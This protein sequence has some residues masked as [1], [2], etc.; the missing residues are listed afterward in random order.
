MAGSGKWSSTT[1][2]RSNDLTAGTLW[3]ERLIAS[4]TRLSPECSTG[5]GVDPALPSLAGDLGEASVTLNEAK[6]SRARVP[7]E[8]LNHEDVVGTSPVETG[9]CRSTGRRGRL[10]EALAGTLVAL[11]REEPGQ[12]RPPLGCTRVLVAA[13]RSKR[14]DQR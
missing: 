11:G 3:I 5:M 12:D 8:H 7:V 14:D 13:K 10:C 1:R 9:F 4:P 2:P 6:D